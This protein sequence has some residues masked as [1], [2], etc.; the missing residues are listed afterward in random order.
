MPT[1]SDLNMEA[2]R[3][4]EAHEEA[5]ERYRISKH[6]DDATACRIAYGVWI[7]ACRKLDKFIQT[8]W[9]KGA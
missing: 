1:L 3:A 8:E 6:P 4:K 2:L 5:I 7:E 9:P